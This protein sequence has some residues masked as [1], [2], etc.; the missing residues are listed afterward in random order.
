MKDK[1]YT[2]QVS[3]HIFESPIRSSSDSVIRCELQ[4]K[5]TFFFTPNAGSCLISCFSSPPTNLHIISKKICILSTCTT[6]ARASKTARAAR[7]VV[8]FLCCSC[9]QNYAAT[10]RIKSFW[11][12]HFGPFSQTIAFAKCPFFAYQ[13]FF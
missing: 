11:F 12:H 13:V 5:L 7:S 6:I 2:N 9:L 3:L 8:Y 4:C 10:K 1:I